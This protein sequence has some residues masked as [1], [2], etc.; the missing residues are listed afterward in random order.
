[1]Y[2]SCPDTQ[3]DMEN[4]VSI[5]FQMSFKVSA[6]I[7]CECF[8]IDSSMEISFNYTLT[9]TVNVKFFVLYIWLMYD[10]HFLYFL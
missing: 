7:I 6:L 4:N 9:K 10:L 2:G 3:I 1:M 5:L 8:S